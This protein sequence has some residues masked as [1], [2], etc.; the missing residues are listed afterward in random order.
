MSF[1]WEVSS[2]G[3]GAKAKC[4]P[5]LPPRANMYCYLPYVWLLDLAMLAT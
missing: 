3:G 2:W 1:P 4:P 5:L